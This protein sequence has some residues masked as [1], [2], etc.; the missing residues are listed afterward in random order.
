[1]ARKLT[2]FKSYREFM[3]YQRPEHIR[4]SS[5]NQMS[6]PGNHN[7]CLVLLNTERSVA[8][9]IAFMSKKVAVVIKPRGGL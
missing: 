2:R 5:L 3:E 7:R 4:I 1:M 8:K 9:P 6:V